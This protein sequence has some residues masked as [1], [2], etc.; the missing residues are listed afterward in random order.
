MIDSFIGLPPDDSVVSF[1]NWLIWLKRS[2]A[3]TTSYF[4]PTILHYSLVVRLFDFVC[5]PFPNFLARKQCNFDEW[6]M[7]LV[8]TYRHPPADNQLHCACA[9]I[10][11]DCRSRSEETRENWPPMLE[12][13]STDPLD[14]RTLHNR[15]PRCSNV[16]QPTPSMLERCST[17]PLDAR[18]LLNW[19]PRCSNVAQLAPSM[20]ERC[21]T[22]PLDARTLLIRAPREANTASNNIDF[23]CKLPSAWGDSWC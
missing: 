18:T 9:D 16:A 14:A 4:G 5:D 11:A 1:S 7:C 22:D 19:P 3:E 8:C 23:S 21:S 6:Y 17:G 12:R 13:C 20:L 10:K 2:F 15:P